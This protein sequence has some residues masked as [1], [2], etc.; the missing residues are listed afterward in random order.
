LTPNKELYLK[1]IE[2]IQ[3]FSPAARVLG[4]A[5]SLLRDPD[6]DISSV[7]D[8]IRTDMALTTDILRGSNSAYYSLGERVSNLDR[9]MQKI[10]FS[11]CIRLLNISVAHTL[12]ARNL[13]NYGITAENFW[14]ESLFNGLF[15]EALARATRATEPDTA[16]TA[17]LLR[18][19]GRLA[20]DQCLH[21]LGSGLFWDGK[22]PMREWEL[23]NV[24]FEQT[25]AAGHLLRAWRFSDEIIE[26]IEHQND[27]EL[28]ED[29]GNLLAALQ[30]AASIVPEGV[31]LARLMSSKEPV[32]DLVET[33]FTSSY[34]ITPDYV[35]EL[36]I[37][38]REQFT[39][40]NGKLYGK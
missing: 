25:E 34:G 11:E 33:R 12:A 19:V 30:F 22:M 14:A 5:I 8:L 21:T 31:G 13:N 17:G 2:K 27:V 29:A 4:Q 16:H 15:M 1:A 24:G 26:A 6:A 18:Y 36:L 9:A 23:E 39:E 37:T 7:A 20:I 40:I 32:G 28:P 38:T 10:G 3:S 35:T